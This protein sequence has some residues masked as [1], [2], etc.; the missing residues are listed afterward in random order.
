MKGG[1]TMDVMDMIA[2]VSFAVTLFIAGYT[3]GKKK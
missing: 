3:I 1:G 2:L